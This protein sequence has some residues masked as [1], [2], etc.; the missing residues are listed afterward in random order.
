MS[1]VCKKPSADGRGGKMLEET[2]LDYSS[3]AML[4]AGIIGPSSIGRGGPNLKGCIDNGAQ[5]ADI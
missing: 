1:D 4:F 5:L 2:C 3:L